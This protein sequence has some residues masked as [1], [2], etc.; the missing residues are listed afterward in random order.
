MLDPLGFFTHW[1]TQPLFQWI[2]DVLLTFVNFAL[3][4]LMAISNNLLDNSVSIAIM[5]VTQLVAIGMFGLGVMFTAYD[6]F[7]GVD[8]S[9]SQWANNNF[10]DKLTSLAMASVFTT[11]YI[12]A[13]KLAFTAIQKMTVDV[14]NV[15]QSGF[16]IELDNYNDLP[17]LDKFTHYIGPGLAIIILI[18]IIFSVWDLFKEGV[19]KVPLLLLTMI[20]GCVKPFSIARGNVDEVFGYIKSIIGI[21]LV[22]MMKLMFFT[23]GISMIMVPHT[24]S[25]IVGIGLVIASKNVEK[26]LGELGTTLSSSYGMRNAMGGAVRSLSMAKGFM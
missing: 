5:D 12:E 24:D 8:N 11:T 19:T 16:L 17:F 3:A 23:W 6:F 4:S 2:S 14:L 15:T 26:G 13:T 25:M 1:L 22:L 7:N 20:V 9:N 10:V 21:G 18:I